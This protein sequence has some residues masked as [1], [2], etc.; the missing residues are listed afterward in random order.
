M[1]DIHLHP[2]GMT[3][4]DV[5]EQFRQV[6]EISDKALAPLWRALEGVERAVLLAFHA[7]KSGIDVSNEF[8]AAVVRRDRARL[9]GFA[10]VDPTE[11]DAVA[12]LETALADPGIRGVKLAPIYQHFAPDDPCAWPVYAWIQKHGLPIMW[13]Q[14]ASFMAPDGPLEDAMPHRLD[15]VAVAFPEIKMVVAHFGYP[16]SAE[17]VAMLRKHRNLYSDVSMLAGRPWFLYNAL[18]AAQEY[19][20]LDKVLFGSDFP[21]CT[22]AQTANALRRVNEV[23][24]AG[25]PRI[26]AEAIEQIIERDSFALLGID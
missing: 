16:W 14:G 9:V 1:I 8:V 7:P 5:Y 10:S 4:R 11:P 20:A 23:A 13:H 15:K 17:T 6:G 22:A 25:M 24:G 2:C 3:A 21:A 18:V 12:Q 19:G 26:T